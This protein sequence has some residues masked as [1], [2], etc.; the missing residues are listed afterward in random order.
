MN[1]EFEKWIRKIGQEF[2]LTKTEWKD[3]TFEYHSAGTQHKWLG[4]MAGRVVPKTKSVDNLRWSHVAFP[5]AYLGHITKMQVFANQLGY[6]MFC[7][8][9]RIYETKTL[10]DTGKKLEDVK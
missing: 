2:L 10:A 3:G 6:P 8:N 9:G 5:H 4:F 1:K 7:W